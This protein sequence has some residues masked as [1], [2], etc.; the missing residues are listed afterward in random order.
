MLEASLDRQLN[1]IAAADSRI[2]FIFAISTAMLGVLAT[3]APV[4]SDKW[5]IGAAVF[6]AL[7]LVFNI[8]SLLLVSFATFP[9][10]DGPKGSIIFFGGIAVTEREQ[11]KQEIMK[12]DTEKYIDDLAKQCH[13]NADIANSKFTWIKRSLISLYLAIIPWGLSVYFIYGAARR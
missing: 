5:S 12:I 6:A 9:R 1:W 4:S 8:A 7:A 2:A 11:F 10:T 3:I 13:V